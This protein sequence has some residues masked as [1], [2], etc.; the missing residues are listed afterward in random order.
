MRLPLLNKASQ[1]PFTGDPDDYRLSLVE[2]LTEL[3]DRLIRS[4]V[5][6]TL[7]SVIGWFIVPT[8]YAFLNGMADAA[9]RA[10]LPK[11]TEYKEVFKTFTDGFMLQF[12][13]SFMVGIGLAFPYLV[14]ELWGFL[15][16][17]LKPNEQ[18]PFKRL[19]PMS[20]LL[21]A[22]GV[23]FA[24]LIIPT[25]LTWFAEYMVNWPSVQLYQDAGS[26]VF[27]IL[28][29]LLA[30]GVAF[31]LPLVVYG[32]GLAGILSA[33]TLVKYWRQAATVVFLASAL[34]TP[35]NDAFSMLMM[36]IP[37]TIL[38]AISVVAV[39]YAQRNKKTLEEDLSPY[40]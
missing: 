15:A 10:A 18:K 21:F 39:R 12:R 8:L 20:I 9:I 14:Y 7:A 28:K 26:M 27:F 2:H 38:F 30:F 35:S 22:T 11:G 13:L 25:A 32:M 1:R 3:R 33:E 4:L 29:M 37:M 31:Q 34:I 40:A 6:L 16:P 36:A 5:V 23:G 17:A 24:W 19:A